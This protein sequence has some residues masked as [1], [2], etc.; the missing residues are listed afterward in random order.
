MSVTVLEESTIH[1][2]GHIDFVVQK[3]ELPNQDTVQKTIIRHPGAVAMIPLMD[4]G[5][6]V[7]VEQYR[8]AAAQNVLEIPAGTLEPGED[9]AA[10]AER[11]LQEEAG[12]FPGELVH[13]GEIFVAPGLTDE[14]IQLFLARDLR[15]SR[16]PQ[17]V[18]EL[19]QVVQMPF[20]EALAQIQDGRIRDAKTIIGLS[21]VQRFAKIVL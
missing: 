16:L 18:D 9:P 8:F 21:Q 12:Y 3:I 1:R 14:R 11:E 17:D 6:V 5:E 19:I 13:L 20:S 10:C 7:L 15:P 4:D 2:Q